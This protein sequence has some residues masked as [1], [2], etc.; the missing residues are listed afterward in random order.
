MNNRDELEAKSRAE[1]LKSLAHPTR[2]FIVDLIFRNGPHCV[3]EL[4]DHVGVDAST[5]SRHLSVLK[6]AGILSDQKDGT[7]VYYDLA[8]DCIGQFMTGLQG[9]VMSKRSRDLEMLGFP[10]DP[11]A[12]RAEGS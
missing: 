11:T 7:K 6:T 3:Q 4:T 2:I 5:V 8:C 1:I 9:V 10:T 12:R